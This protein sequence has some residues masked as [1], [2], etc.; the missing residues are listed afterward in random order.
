MPSLTPPTKTTFV[1]SL[2]LF[3]VALAGHVLPALRWVGS[4]ELLAL[5]YVVLAAG[6]LI[7]GV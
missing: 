3:I 2:L 7:R 1:I 4:W 6:V 5:A